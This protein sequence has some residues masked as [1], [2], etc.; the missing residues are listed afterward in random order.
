MSVATATGLPL[1]G[2]LHAAAVVDD[3]TLDNITDE[4]LR[5]GLGAK[6]IRRVV[7]ACQ[8]AMAGTDGANE[9]L[10]WFCNFLLGRGVARL[11]G[12]P[13]LLS[14]ARSTPSRHGNAAKA[15]RPARS[16]GAPGP[17]SAAVPVWQNAVT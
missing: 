4:L 3:A 5:A 10:D 15:F 1:R 2:I 7:P 12:G 8:A 9:D 16:P 6:G 11:A 14:P 13:R 17:T